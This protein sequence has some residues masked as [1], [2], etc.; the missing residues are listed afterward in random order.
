[1]GSKSVLVTLVEVPSSQCNCVSAITQWLA[2]FRGASRK[3]C[4]YGSQYFFFTHVIVNLDRAGSSCHIHMYINICTGEKLVPYM[5][6][7]LII[8]PIEAERLLPGILQ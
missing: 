2:P 1:M 7:P 3:D 8:R 6:A 5:I 4:V